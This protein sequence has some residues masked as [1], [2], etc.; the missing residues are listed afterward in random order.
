VTAYDRAG[1]KPWSNRKRFVVTV[2]QPT[3]AS[4]IEGRITGQR[5]F[6]KQVGAANLQHPGALIT[7]TVDAGGQYGM[8]NRPDGRCRVYPLAGGKF[9]VISQPRH[10]D[11]TCRG[12]QSHT[13]NFEMTG[14][15]EG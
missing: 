13:V 15:F 6:V 12:S 10:R 5:R 1:N 11:V 14:V 4:S 3:C 2:P 9:E 8:A 7:A